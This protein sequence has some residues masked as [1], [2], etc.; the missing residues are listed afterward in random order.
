MPEMRLRRLSSLK[1]GFPS[2]DF[3]PIYL[4]KHQIM[5][6]KKKI[7]KKVGKKLLATRGFAPLTC[8]GRGIGRVPG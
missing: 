5:R 4:R 6:S 8:V 2:A 7:L 1:A 3:T